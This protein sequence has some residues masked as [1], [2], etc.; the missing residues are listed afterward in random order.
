MK[1]GRESIRIAGFGELARRRRSFE[2]LLSQVWLVLLQGKVGKY[3]NGRGFLHRDSW[4]YNKWR[5]DDNRLQ[6]AATQ[7]CCAIFQ[8]WTSTFA[9]AQI[10]QK[11]SVLEFPARTALRRFG[12]LAELCGVA[13]LCSLRKAH[14]ADQCIPM[15]Q[16]LSQMLCQFGS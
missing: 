15:A 10:L 1:K 8:N 12:L 3:T 14:G 11:P 6:T 13:E 16:H 4:R 5:T 7:H 9:A 2:T